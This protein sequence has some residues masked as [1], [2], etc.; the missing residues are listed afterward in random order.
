LQSPIFPNAVSTWEDRGTM[1]FDTETTSS[2]T[3]P[4]AFNKDVRGCG[5]KDY[6]AVSSALTLQYLDGCTPRLNGV[7]S[8]SGLFYQGALSTEIDDMVYVLLSGSNGTLQPNFYSAA[9]GL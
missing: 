5:E 9:S 2:V 4:I 8:L 6:R 3:K 1:F 7:L